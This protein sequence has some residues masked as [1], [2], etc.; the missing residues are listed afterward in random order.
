[1]ADSQWR[2]RSEKILLAKINGEEYTDPPL[3]RIEELLIELDTGGGGGG[4]DGNYNNL[5]DKPKINGVELK[6]DKSF[7]DLGLNAVT[8]EEYEEMMNDDNP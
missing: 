2:S 7:A 8:A 5:V 6:G 4:G 1:M 3:S